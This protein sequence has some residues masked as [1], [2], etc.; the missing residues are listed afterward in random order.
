MVK[1]TQGSG[2]GQHS[3][4]QVE[5]TRCAVGRVCAVNVHIVVP[6]ATMSG[7]SGPDC[8][9]RYSKDQTEVP[10]LL[11]WRC[12]HGLAQSRVAAV[13]SHDYLWPNLVGQ[14]LC[15]RRTWCWR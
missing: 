13:A 5:V 9:T 14:R 2:G 10:M 1:V 11:F 6:L 12:R 4:A 7:A 8:G 3:E 15:L